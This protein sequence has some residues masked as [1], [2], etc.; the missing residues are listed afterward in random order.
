MDMKYLYCTPICEEVPALWA[1]VLCASPGAGES[2]GV[3]YE[4]WDL[5]F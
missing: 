1:T 2:E 3:G 4:D 5:L